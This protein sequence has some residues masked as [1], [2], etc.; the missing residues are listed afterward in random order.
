MATGVKPRK[1]AEKAAESKPVR[2]WARVGIASRGVLYVVVA[3]LAAHLAVGDFDRRTDK[4][5][6]IATVA[7]QPFGRLLVLA[8]AIGFAG[9]T[10]WRVCEVV[11]ADSWAKRAASAGKATLYGFI[12]STAVAYIVRAGHQSPKR[13]HDITTRV[14]GWPGGRWLVAAAGLA[15]IGAGIYNGYRGLSQR[16]LKRLRLKELGPTERRIVHVL[17]IA[18]MTAR[19]LVFLVVGWFFVRAAVRFDPNEPIGLDAALRRVATGSHGP[20]V[21]GLIAAGLLAY[22]LY[23]FAEA[24]YRKILDD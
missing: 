6:A 13:E 16:Y 23:T 19:M 22:G 5:G 24:R 1:E 15:I 18:G 8:L 17:A 11:L 21:L 20:L 12:C 9:Y 3:L 10:V 14:M 2:A 4:D 7:H